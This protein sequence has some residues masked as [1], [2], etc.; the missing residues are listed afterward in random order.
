MQ[1]TP[2][3][4]NRVS[5]GATRVRFSVLAILLVTIFVAYL[6]RANISVLVANDQFL[7]EMG[8]AGRPASIGL[9][10]TAFL[11]T[12]GISNVVLS[13]LGDFLGPRKAM[14]ISV[15]LWIVAA[16]M[17]GIVT[18]FAAMIATRVLLGAG[19][20]IH[21]PMQSV[22]VKKWFPPAE[23]GRAN[24]V[25]LTGQSLASA[26]AMPF[27]AWTILMFGWRSSFFI[28]AALGLIPLYLLWFHAT[29][30]PRQNRRV[31]EQELRHIEAELPDA[32]RGM[33]TA[34]ESVWHSARTFIGSYQYWLIVIYDICHS[35][36]YWGLASWIPSYLKA[37]RGFS[38]QQMGWIAA[39]PFILEMIAKIAG[40]L[41]ADRGERNALICFISMLGSALSIYF[42]VTVANPYLAALLISMGV[43]MIGLGSPSVWALTQRIVPHTSIAT[44]SGLLNGVATW[45]GSLS[46]TIIGICIALSGGSYAGGLFS[47]VAT[48]AIGMLTALLLMQRKL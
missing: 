13:P 42:G 47:L 33:A 10:M 36:V 35:M 23:R 43:G 46:P 29:D 24:S 12:Y 7:H 17:G 39:L 1:A 2:D 6:D 16:T 20:G 38:W 19:E 26:A 21:Y 9:L 3:V 11:F 15:V 30:T 27:F 4:M 48:T 31:N 28:C 32:A 25:W 37:A 14:C 22:F 8:I 5:A 44:A 34:K 18:T 40:G 41:L 45:F